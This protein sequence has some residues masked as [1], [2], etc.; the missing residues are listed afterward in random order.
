MKQWGVEI[1]KDDLV[2][3]EKA[4]K[5]DKEKVNQ[6]HAMMMVYVKM[7]NDMLEHLE[8]EVEYGFI[9]EKERRKI[10]EGMK[11]IA[12]VYKDQKKDE[13]D[14][15]IKQKCANRI[16]KQFGDKIRVVEVDAE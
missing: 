13:V 8:I 11:L 10:M 16:E 12:E 5:E 3:I 4:I 6:E 9:T 15:R 7:M 2:E 14:A 1:E